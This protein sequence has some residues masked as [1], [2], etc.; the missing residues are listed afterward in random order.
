MNTTLTALAV[1]AVG[2]ILAYVVFDRLRDKF[3]YVGGAEY[4]IIGVLFGPHATGFLSAGVISELTPVVS[5]ALG[6]MGMLLGS[7]FRLPVLALLRPTHV[8][9]AFTEATATFALALGALISV[10]HWAVGYSWADAAIPAVTLAA[11][12]TTSAPAAIDALARR[13]LGVSRLFGVLQ[14]TSRVDGLIGV[15]AFGLVVA[16]LH[17]GQVAE[18]VRQPTGT[19]WAVINIAV[20]VASGIL[21]HL[22]LGPRESVGTQDDDARLFV[23]LAGAIVVASGASYYL[24]LSPIFTNLI[25]G[26]ILA[27]TG[28]AHRDVA[29]LLA[30]T[31]RPVYLMLLLF[32]GSAWTPSAGGL[33]FI[34]PAFIAIRLIARLGGGWLA[35]T[36]D[37]PPEL[38]TPTLGRGLLGMGGLSV[39]IGLNYTQI[40]PEL[41]P[42]VILTATLGAVLLFE[43]LATAEA[44]AV[45]RQGMPPEPPP[46]APPEPIGTSS[47]GGPPLPPP[48]PTA[49]TPP[50]TPAEQ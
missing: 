13:G 20:G 5:L 38:K 33:L 41:A 35:G 42:D 9:M 3:G 45:L 28:N 18:S 29:R 11:I 40:H 17:S 25:L 32:A 7:Y 22:F 24:N 21:F 15:L 8:S 47:G 39:A 6:W 16:V 50:A 26:F 49:T 37:V 12:A 2:Y 19:E 10:F 44:S 31:E 27:N 34:A 43:I 23:A 46:E 4:L 30:K 14:F 48:E 36:V 1:V